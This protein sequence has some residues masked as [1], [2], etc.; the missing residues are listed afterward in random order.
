MHLH[1]WTER[2]LS[3]GIIKLKRHAC[4]GSVC[5][6]IG[7]FFLTFSKNLKPQVEL[8]LGKMGGGFKAIMAAS[9]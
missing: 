2:W 7:W 3:N 5:S 1:I 4:I 8:L 6:D 9:S